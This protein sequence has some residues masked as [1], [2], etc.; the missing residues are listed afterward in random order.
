MPLVNGPA[1]SHLPPYILPPVFGFIILIFALFVICKKMQKKPRRDFLLPANP[2]SSPPVSTRPLLKQE[3]VSRG[4]FGCVWKADY[5]SSIVA[6]KVIQ[7]Q[8]KS[9]WETE[10]RIYTSYG[11]KHENILNFINAEMRCENNMFEYLIITEFHEHGSLS[12]YLHENIVDFPSLMRLTCSM[13]TGLAYLHLNDFELNSKKPI[14]SHRDFKSRNVLVK[15]NLTCCISDF[16]SACVFS[17]GDENEDARA[18]VVNFFV[19]NGSIFIC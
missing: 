6:V 12:D 17:P 13:V 10:K 19:V 14:I 4:Q 1:A 18:Q 16:G 11:L 15:S 8:E 3:I 5:E 7:A 9:S 2:R